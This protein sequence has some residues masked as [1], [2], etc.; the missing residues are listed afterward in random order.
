M[1]RGSNKAAGSVSL[2]VQPSL[3]FAPNVAAASLPV[4]V[5]GR[6]VAASRRIE[7]QHGPFQAA[8]SVIAAVG[9]GDIA[10]AQVDEGGFTRVMQTPMTV[11]VVHI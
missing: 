10:Q 4:P 7:D 9:L 5:G 2:V 3:E 11:D 1:S 6:E 8:H